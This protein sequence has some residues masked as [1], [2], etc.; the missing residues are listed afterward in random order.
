MAASSNFRADRQLSRHRKV[1]WC[2]VPPAQFK[3]GLLSKFAVHLNEIRHIA[4]H[5]TQATD[6]STIEPTRI[7]PEPV[8]PPARF[9]VHRCLPIELQSASARVVLSSNPAFQHVSVHPFAQSLF[10]KL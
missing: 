1:S 5:N 8:R 2:L 7:H 4:I 3:V 6:I 10:A 9:E